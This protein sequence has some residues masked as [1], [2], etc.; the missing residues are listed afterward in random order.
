MPLDE[1]KAMA[2]AEHRKYP[3]AQVFC[4]GNP[5]LKKS[6]S[7]AVMRPMPDEK[8][9]G[10]IR[11]NLFRPDPVNIKWWSPVVPIID[12]KP[13]KS[14]TYF[15]LPADNDY[16]L[17]FIQAVLPGKYFTSAHRQIVEVFG[18]PSDH[19]EAALITESLVTDVWQGTSTWMLI[20]SR[21][22]TYQHDFT[23]TYTNAQMAKLAA[24]HGFNRSSD[25]LYYSAHKHYR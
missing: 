24:S 5:E 1:F 25:I 6:T 4:S 19:A 10:I 23:L 3:T 13:I 9:A 8:E 22:S 21:K 17:L 18:V 2:E 20:D 7:L 16:R 11:C 12:G 14:A 15:F